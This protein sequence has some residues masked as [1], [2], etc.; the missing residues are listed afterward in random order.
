VAL[1]LA[2]E[3]SKAC[4]RKIEVWCN[5]AE[6]AGRAYGR[7]GYPAMAPASR[8]VHSRRARKVLKDIREAVSGRGS[9]VRSRATVGRRSCP[10]ADR[11]PGRPGPMTPP[12][13]PV[14]AGAFTVTSNPHRDQPRR[15]PHDSAGRGNA[16]GRSERAGLC[17]IRQWGPPSERCKYSAICANYLNMMT[18]GSLRYV[19]SE[20]GCN[21][22]DR[23]G[24]VTQ[25]ASLD[26]SAV[27]NQ[28]L[29]HASTVTSPRLISRGIPPC[30]IP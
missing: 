12:G 14:A 23:P 19:I 10:I 9:G 16:E 15:V 26:L 18:G 4:N 25:R 3:G 27:D 24:E 28:L 5:A 20:C 29:I 22:E 17:T 30:L 6:A 1:R 13:T 21:C 11:L 2:T 8:I 7:R